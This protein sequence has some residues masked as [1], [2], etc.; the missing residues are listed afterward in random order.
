M[1]LFAIYRELYCRVEDLDLQKET[2]NANRLEGFSP[3]ALLTWIT[4]S[5]APGWSQSISS[6]EAL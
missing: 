5:P 2:C 3:S 1:Q 6:K 4:Q